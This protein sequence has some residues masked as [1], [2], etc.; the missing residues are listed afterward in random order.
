MANH[1]HQIENNPVEA[2][3]PNEQSFMFDCDSGRTIIVKRKNIGVDLLC[4]ECGQKQQV[5]EYQD[6]AS[7]SVSSPV[8]N[9]KPKSDLFQTPRRHW[10][11][12]PTSLI[13]GLFLLAASVVGSWFLV[14]MTKPLIVNFGISPWTLL[15]IAVGLIVMFV[16]GVTYVIKG[17]V[18][19]LI[20]LD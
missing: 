3:R 11:L 6:S 7:G 10:S 18:G 16:M 5:P 4:P 12:S 8:A 13:L 17:C 19:D 2:K 20:E 1:H 14:T 15:L 9:V